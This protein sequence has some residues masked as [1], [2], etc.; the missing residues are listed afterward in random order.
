MAFYSNHEI[1]LLGFRRLGKNVLLSKLTSIY[2]P[3]NI[4]IDDN[5]RIDDFCILSAGEGGIHI[6]KHVH[7]ACYSSL[8]GRGKITISDFAN[9]SSRVSIYSS[10]DDYSGNTMSNSTIPEIYKNV[11]HADVFIDRHVIISSNTVIL[12]AT[13]IHL[14]AVVGAF[15]F[16][17]KDVPSFEVFAGVPAKFIKQRNN[18]LLEVETQFLKD[19][20]SK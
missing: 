9:I 13:N 7:I 8:I 12:P 17:K 11:M 2:H 5:T 15:S 4:S 16:V 3:E 14:G 1:Q 19:Q 18:K 10:N 20:Q 6:G